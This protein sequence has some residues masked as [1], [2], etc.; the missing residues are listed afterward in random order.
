MLF[1]ALALVVVALLGTIASLGRSVPSLE[2]EPNR[3]DL[4]V[5][6]QIITVDELRP[7]AEAVA[8]RDGRIHVVGSREEVLAYKGTATRVVELGDAVLLPGLIDAHSHP[9]LSA[10]MSQTLDISGFHHSTRAEVMEVIDRG[11]AQAGGGEWVIAYGW[12]PALVPDLS[13]PTLAELDAIAPNNP[14]L[15]IAQTLHSAHANSAAFSAAGI[16]RDSPDPAGGYFERDE[17]G[18][19]T[20]GIKEVGAMAKLREAVPKYPTAAYA[21]LLAQQWRAYAQAGYTTVCAPGLQ[22]SI[23]HHL[24]VAQVTAEDGAAPVRVVTYPLHDRLAESSFLPGQGNERFRVLG[25][26][27]WVDGSPYAG[28]MAMEESYVDGPFNRD[29]LGIPSGSRGELHFTDAELAGLVERYHRAGWQVAAHTQGERAV[30]QFL[31]AVDAAQRSFPRTD[32][33]HRMEHNALITRSQLRRARMLGVT[34]SFYMDHVGYYGDALHDH[35]VGSQRAARFMPIGSAI[36]EGHRASIHTDT[37]SSPLGVFRAL[38][39]A[40]TR[41]TRSGRVLGPDE[42]ISVDDALRAVTIDAAWQ[43]FAEASVGSISVGKRADFT[44]LSASPYDVPARQW[45]EIEVVDTYL[46]GERVPRDE[47]S[48]LELGLMVKAAWGVVFGG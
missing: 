7:R 11:V 48:Q 31:G 9:I 5:L 25:P 37:P 28:G 30:D 44:V 47:R 32:H 26:K 42:R 29:V 15:I 36:E 16:T 2:E 14:L 40:V 13:P 21:M 12:D 17:D 19:L 8:V 27:L 24:A 38:S 23:P 35:I 43:I 22:P 10:M 39:T 33:R 41:A 34:V 18:E 3:A 4:I 45:N 6:G 1:I 46:S 20:G